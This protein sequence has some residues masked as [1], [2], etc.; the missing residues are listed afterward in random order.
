MEI[1]KEHLE[2]LAKKHGCKSIE[3]RKATEEDIHIDP[4]VNFNACLRLIGSDYP[5]LERATIVITDEAEEVIVGVKAVGCL[6]DGGKSWFGDVVR[7]SKSEPISKIFD[8]MRSAF[9][10]VEALINDQNKD[11]EA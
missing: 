2:E 1:T 8:G 3:I 11:V 10:N 4:H 6:P 9:K 7:L 5:E